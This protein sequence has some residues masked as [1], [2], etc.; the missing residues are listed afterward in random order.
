MVILD[1]DVLVH[2][3]ENLK[4][5]KLVGDMRTIIGI[6]IDQFQMVVTCG[7]NAPNSKCAKRVERT[8]LGSPKN[9]SF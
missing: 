6:L 5:P 7:P 4:C 3:W 9:I 1:W 8:I 2:Y